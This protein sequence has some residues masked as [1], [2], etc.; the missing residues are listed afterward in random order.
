[1]A[2]RLLV[3]IAVATASVRDPGNRHLGG[4]VTV[5]PRGR[6]SDGTFQ[7]EVHSLQ[8]AARCHV[9]PYACLYGDC[10]SEV[11]NGVSEVSSGSGWC[12]VESRVLIKLPLNHPIALGYP[13]PEDQ[14]RGGESWTPNVRGSSAAWAMMA[15]IDLGIRSDTQESNRPPVSAMLPV[16]RVTRNCPRTFRLLVFDPDGDRVRCR[17]PTVSGSDEC[18]MCGG[19]AGLTLDQDSC[20]LE[21]SSSGA[22]GRHPVELMVEDFPE[23]EIKL[24]YSQ[25]YFTLKRPPSAA[26]SKRFV[27]NRSGLPTASTA[28]PT[29]STAPPTASTAPPTTSISSPTASTAP[30]T[31]TTTDGTTTAP[32]TASTAPPTKTT[33]DGTTTAL[34]TTTTTASWTKSSSAPTAI[35]ATTSSPTTA[36][37]PP[38]SITTDRTTTPAPPTA[39]ADR[40]S[41]LSDRTSPAESYYLTSIPPLSK[42]PLQFTVHVDSFDAPSCLDGLYFPVFLAPTPEN[43]MNLPASVGQLLEIKVRSKARFATIGDLAVIGPGGIMK[44]FVSSGSYVIRWKP[45][46]RDLGGYYPVCFTSEARDGSDRLYQSKPRCVTVEVSRYEAV[47][48]CSQTAMRV[49]VKKNAA[50]RRNQDRLRLRDAGDASCSLE[51]RSNATHLV[52]LLSLNA[53]GT[54]IEEDEATITFKNEI[55]SADLREIITRK[56]EIHIAVSCIYPKKANLTLGFRHKNPYAFSQSGFGSFSFQ[57]EFFQ[58][59]LFRRQVEG[60]SYPV[61]VSLKQMV[62]MQIQASSSIPDTQL[63]VESCRATPYD[64]PESRVSYTIMEDGCVRDPTVQVY[65]GPG[66]VFQFGME[67]FEFIGAHDEVYITCSVLLCQSGVPNTRCSQGCLESGSGRSRREA[68]AQTSSHFIS[69]GPLRLRASDNEAPV[70][71][72]D[73]SLNPS[74]KSSLNPSP[75]PSLN[76]SLSLVLNLVLAVG[77]LL[78]CV[79]LI[80]RIRSRSS[81]SRTQ[82]QRLPTFEFD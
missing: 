43:G 66:S 45:A 13:T 33:T 56:P 72:P 64:N 44:H 23:M 67:A 75:K 48:T 74:P 42:I 54:Q 20:S 24:H 61:E 5:V 69:Q 6:D 59:Q 16:V 12:A 7:V 32:T 8:S 52:V 71:V 82:Y 39:P 80:Y 10:G 17:V 81:R 25:G 78:V 3:L 4:S 31:N 36:T 60:S 40:T 47:V 34:P 70:T 21:Y 65:P 58:S 46:A 41:S 38:T 2:S 77:C 57:F 14:R 79:A 1:M 9:S 26:R 73:L 76:L 53:C 22:A 68:G 27:R 30:P 35:S 63:F 28:P 11:D 37:P 19:S 51:R 62:Y 49:E 15:H 55:T 29:A 50:I 18:G